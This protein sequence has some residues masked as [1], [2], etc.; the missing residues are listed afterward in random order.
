MLGNVGSIVLR[1]KVVQ[2]TEVSRRF[3]WDHVLLVATIR[4]VKGE[5]RQSSNDV[6]KL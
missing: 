5:S 3:G 6:V 2:A 4:E 1:C